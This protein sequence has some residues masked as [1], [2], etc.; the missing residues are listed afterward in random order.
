[1]IIREAHQQLLV[2]S[3]VGMKLYLGG[4]SA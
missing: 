3:H 2:D 1:V 4:E